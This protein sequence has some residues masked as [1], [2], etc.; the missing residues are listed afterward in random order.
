MKKLLL[1]ALMFVSMTAIAQRDVTKF[2]GIPVDG[3][4][5]DM[6]EKLIG[7][8]FTYNEDKDYFEGEFN[9]SK[10]NVFIVTNNNK[11]W[12]IM[13]AD[14]IPCSETNIRIRFNNLC[15][16]FLKNKKYIAF[17]LE[18][19]DYIIPE[20]EDISYEM[21]VNKK[22]YEAAFYQ[23]PDTTLLD[24]VAIQNRIMK[25]LLKEYT[26]N[27]IDNPSDK[28]MKKMD[29]IVKNEKLNMIFEI[30]E[31][32]MVWFNINERYGNYYISIFYEN[33]Y[34]RADGEDL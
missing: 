8:G 16:Q 17:D 32:K 11:V 19:A 3:Y 10:V 12:R 18:A 1:F 13:V 20:D 9:G 2:L 4:K 34:N 31:K 7:K 6:K 14:A 28:Q 24:T 23:I 27:E 22:R 25:E 26:Q 15:R 29:L 30:M 21:L 33:E 5:S